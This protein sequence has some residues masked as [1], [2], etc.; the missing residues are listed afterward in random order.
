MNA[1]HT[2]EYYHWEYG[3]LIDLRGLPDDDGRWQSTAAMFV[4]VHRMGCVAA[5]RYARGAAL[6]ARSRTLSCAL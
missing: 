1:A 4:R 5:L 2:T 6:H 3:R